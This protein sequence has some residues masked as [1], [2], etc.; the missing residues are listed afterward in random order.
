[1]KHGNL[2]AACFSVAAM[3]YF[4]Q[5]GERYAGGNALNQAVR[6]RDLGWN[7]AFL[8]SLGT[9]SAGDRIEDLLSRSGV[10]LS[11]MRRIPGE[12]A[13]NELINDEQG[14][15]FGVEGAW[16]NG[17][18]PE[19]ALSDEDWAYIAD[20]PVW[21]THAN[22]NN[23]SEA[24]KRKGPDNFLA[25]DYLHFDTYDELKAGLGIVDIAYFGGREEQLPELAELSRQ[26]ETLIVLTLGAGGSIALRRG[27]SFLQEALPL[28]PVVDT[29]GCGDAF[30]AGF[31]DSFFRNRN[32]PAALLAGAELGRIAA[33]FPGGVPWR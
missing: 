32:I 22:G 16:K 10:D 6:F 29:T 2:K 4:P 17:V 3:D 14:E 21:S 28:D 5:R 8:G 19:Y 7:T 31:T 1:M 11:R 23:Y 18:Y 20:F 25:V 24:L 12:T 30:Q 13:C 26:S 15:R 9:D 33:S 27:D